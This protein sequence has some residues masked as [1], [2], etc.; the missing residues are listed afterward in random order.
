MLL[1]ELQTIPGI[2]VGLSQDLFDLGYRKA[3]DLK[4]EDPELLKWW[5]WKDKKR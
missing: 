2:G 5:N 4:G 1:K 3:D